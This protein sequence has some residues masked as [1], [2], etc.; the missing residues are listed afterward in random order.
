[1]SAASPTYDSYVAL[2]LA[3]E[4]WDDNGAFCR[5]CE[6][7]TAASLASCFDQ[8]AERFGWARRDPR[9]GAMRDGDRLVGWGCATAAS[10]ANTGVATARVTLEPDGR[11]KVRIAAHEL[12]TGT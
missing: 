9:P 7:A 12:G 2:K 5:Y 1:V 3:R 11:A 8:A 4:E 6:T 10:P